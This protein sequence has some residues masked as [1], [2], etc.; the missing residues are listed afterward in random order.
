L[1]RG[2]TKSKS[3]ED[4]EERLAFLAA[5]LDSSVSD[6]QGTVSL[7]LLSKDVDEGLAILRDVLSAPRFQ[8]NKIAL[9]K[10]QTLQEMQQRNDDSSAIEGR[11]AGFLAYGENFWANRYSTKASVDSL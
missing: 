2:G 9:R 11:E 3:A 10:Q 6:N 8:D 5:N 7:N 4:M 1:A